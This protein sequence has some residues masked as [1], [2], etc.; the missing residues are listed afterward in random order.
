MIRNLYLVAALLVISPCIHAK[1]SLLTTEEK[2]GKVSIAI[3]LEDA[4]DSAARIWLPYPIS[5][6][7]QQIEDVTIS[8]NLISPATYQEPDS[9]GH[10]LYGEWPAATASKSLQ[11]TFKVR[12]AQHREK[13]LVATNEPI[14]VAVRKYLEASELIPIDGVV[15]ETAQEIIH[16]EQDILQRA[17]AVYDWVVENTYRDPNVKG[18][19]TGIVEITLA[20]RSG[21]CADLSSVYVALARASGVPAREVFGLRLGKEEQQDITGGYHCWAEFY[22]PG[23]G[24]VPV[25]PADVRKIMLVQKLDLGAAS[26]YREFYFGNIDSY[27]I[28]LVKGGRGINLLPQQQAGALNYF[29]YPYAEVDGKALD[30]LEPESFRYSVSFDAI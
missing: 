14:P 20:R 25:D 12:A 1:S 10:Y 28:V 17:R 13:N 15:A 19:G 23:T 6:T 2:E 16:D 29:M 24:W 27:R 26:S 7:H 21:K 3:S 22:L 11:L 4:A 9:G 8:G 18:C 30:Y 5:D